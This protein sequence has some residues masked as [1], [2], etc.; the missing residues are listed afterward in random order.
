MLK[1][2]PPNLTPKTSKQGGLEFRGSLLTRVRR[3]KWRSTKRSKYFFRDNNKIRDRKTP[4][5]GAG[6]CCS[7]AV[8]LRYDAVSPLQGDAGRSCKLAVIASVNL[9][10]V[11]CI[12]EL[13]E[14]LKSHCKKP[15]WKGLL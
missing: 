15:K 13:V 1:L 7:K 12:S 4:S 10:P 3:D 2:N 6:V 14:R 9:D 11:W 8:F 5:P